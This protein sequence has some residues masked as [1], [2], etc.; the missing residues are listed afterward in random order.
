MPLDTT[1]TRVYLGASRLYEDIIM[2]LRRA[3][4]FTRRVMLPLLFRSLLRHFDS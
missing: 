2:L 1:S 4:M 3:A